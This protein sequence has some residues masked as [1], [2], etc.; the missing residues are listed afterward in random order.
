MGARALRWLLRLLPGEFREGYAREIARTVADEARH[1]SGPARRRALVRLWLATAGDILRTAPGQHWD[2]LRRDVTFALRTMASRPAHTLTTV[3]VLGLALGA[4]VAMFAV[5]DAVLLAPLDY[6]DADRVVLVQEAGRASAAGP[7]GYL[8]YA[9]LKARAHSFGA[10]AAATQSTATFTGGG[11]DAERVNAM[12]VSREYF[13]MVGVTP[14]LGRAFTAAEDQPGA[15]RRVVVLSDALWQRRFGGDPSAIGRVVDLGGVP[16]TIVGVMPRGFDD[17]VASRL[18]KDAALWTPLGYDPAASFACRTCRHLRVFGRLQPGVTPAAAEAELT[19]IL[20]QLASEHTG[21]YADPVARVQRLGDLFLGPVRPAVLLLWGGVLLLLVVACA[22]VAGLML[23]RASERTTEV[24]VRAALGVTPARLARQLVTEA[25]LLAMIGGAAG[26]LPA[27]LVVRGLR[28]AGPA[29]LPRLADAV[30]DGRAL[31]AGLLLALVSGVCF[32]VAPLVKLWR[33]Q[34]ADALR[35]AGRR[36]DGVHTW[37]VRAAL[38][39]S[40]VAMAGVLLAGTGVLV[41]SV[42]RLLAVDP[43]VRTA[44]LLT[45]KVW[46]G[47]PRLTAGDTPQQVAAATA[48][49][50]EVLGRIRALPAVRAAAAVST[51][52]LSGDLD[53]IGFHVAGLPFENPEEAPQADRFSVAGDYFAALGVPVVAGRVLDARDGPEAP[54]VAVVNQTAVETVFGGESPLGRQVMLGPPTAAP[55]TIVGVVADVRHRG[56]DRPAGVQV[57]VPQAQWAYPDTLMTLLVGTTGE[58][59]AVAGAVRAAVRDVDPTQPITDVRRMDDVLAATTGTRRFV[60]G[61]LGVFAVLAVLLSV[62]GLYGVLSVMVAQRRVEIGIRLALGARADAIRRMV[63]LHGLRPA[64]A[65]AAI[66]LPLAVVA[67]RAGRSLL[68]EVP[69][70]DAPALGAAAAILIA[71]S[72]A[73]CAIPAWRAARIDPAV[74]LRA[75]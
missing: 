14:A 69:P 66:G 59:M 35:G 29:D 37:R 46:A 22:N 19:G 54:R 23:L 12:R 20:R 30:I 57:Y 4:N 32:G 63:F 33:A 26:V 6:R 8:T 34:R 13:E 61:V 49:Y 70:G 5:A 7:T 72:A 3:A 42:S 38:A 53:G 65:G 51:L 73:A 68:F 45:M 48:Y 52:P 41:R 47:G 25:A 24:A 18:Y 50:S 74:S 56:L 44:G 67:L 10:L 39:A 60:T 21:A 71:A 28:G 64:L 2:I 31:A 62:V 15:A 17:L 27:W 75:E 36:T 43:G 16:F 11:L 58:P 55:R 9:D 1:L 40:S